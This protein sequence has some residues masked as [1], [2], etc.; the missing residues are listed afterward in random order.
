M[1]QKVWRAEPS[2]LFGVATLAAGAKH[3]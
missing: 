2:A 1:A 3:I